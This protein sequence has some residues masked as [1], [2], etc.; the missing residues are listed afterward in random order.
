MEHKGPAEVDQ[1]ISQDTTQ[2]KG[3][4]KR[5]RPLRAMVG[6]HSHQRERVKE[7]CNAQLFMMR[8]LWRPTIDVKCSSSFLQLLGSKF[9]LIYLIFLFVCFWSPLFFLFLFLF[10][11]LDLG[12]AL[13]APFPDAILL[14]TYKISQDTIAYNATSISCICMIDG[15]VGIR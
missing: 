3:E 2:Y 6:R 5:L 1:I 7:V 4:G 11:L 10:P 9:V 13:L 12:G 15:K 14:I 8:K